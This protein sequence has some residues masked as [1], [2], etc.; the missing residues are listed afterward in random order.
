MVVGIVG[1][2]SAPEPPEPQGA[3]QTLREAV[4]EPL[5]SF[6]GAP[7]GVLLLLFVLIFKL[8]DYLAGRMTMPFLLDSGLSKTEIATLRQAFGL[9][10]TIVGAL[11]GGG[12]VARLGILRS[13]VLFGVLQALS[14]AGFLW[15]AAGETVTRTA[16]A[17]VIAVESL[18]TGLVAAGFVAFLMSCCDRRYS[19]TQYAL[20]T[21]AMLAGSK[22]AGP[23]AGT[24][25]GGLGYA[26]FFALTIAAGVPGLAMLPWIR[27]HTPAQEAQPG[28]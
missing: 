14:N 5:R 17:T 25:A 6:F 3:P 24:V 13:L 11:I 4:V 18:C 7:G 12:V 28:G 20:L 16:A 27:T 22:L 19:A 23:V 2:L 9:A 1:T 21:S 8:P 26:W 10:M 15:L